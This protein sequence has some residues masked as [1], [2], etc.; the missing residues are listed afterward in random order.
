[1]KKKLFLVT[2]ALL[3]SLTSFSQ[4]YLYVSV[5]NESLKPDIHRKGMSNNEALN[6]V[7]R[8]FEVK[9]YYQSFLGAKKNLVNL[10]NLMKIL[11]Q[12]KNLKNYCNFAKLKIFKNK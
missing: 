6:Q 11:V 1:M 4:Y 5:R 12:D 9:S 2:V 7:F 8:D 10:E 3:V